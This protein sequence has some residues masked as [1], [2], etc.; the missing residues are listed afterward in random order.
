MSISLR[1]ANV[2]ENAI[3]TVS[4]TKENDILHYN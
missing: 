1:S 3:F 4:A 2:I